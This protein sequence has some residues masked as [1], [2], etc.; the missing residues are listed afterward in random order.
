MLNQPEILLQ[1]FENQRSD[2]ERL[3]RVEVLT[4]EM[5]VAIKEIRDMQIRCPGRIAEMQRQARRAGLVMAGKLLGWFI[6]IV[7]A[8]AGAYTAVAAIF[9]G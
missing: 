2:S 1:I 5:G 4:N 8:C 3:A 6:G 9:G 7:T